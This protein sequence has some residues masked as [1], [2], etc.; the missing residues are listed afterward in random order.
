M[1]D[2][3]TL[4]VVT[5]IDAKLQE[6]CSGPLQIASETAQTSF[7]VL[8]AC[9][10]YTP[11]EC[12]INSQDAE[13]K[14]NFDEQPATRLAPAAAEPPDDLPSEPNHLQ[15]AKE[16]PVK[17][18]S[19]KDEHEKECIEAITEDV[20]RQAQDG[21]SSEP[22]PLAERDPK[23]AAYLAIQE[24]V[25]GA[26]A[27]ETVDCFDCSSPPLE[28]SSVQSVSNQEADKTDEADNSMLFTNIEPVARMRVQD[29][30]RSPARPAKYDHI[31][32]KLYHSTA[33]AKAK[34]VNSLERRPSKCSCVVHCEGGGPEETMLREPL[35]PSLFRMACDS[36]NNTQQ[37]GTRLLRLHAPSGTAIVQRPHTRGMP[38]ETANSGLPSVFARS[39]TPTPTL[40]AAGP[41]KVS[42][43]LQKRSINPIQA[44]ELTSAMKPRIYYR[45]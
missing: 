3:N 32:S 14:Q 7:H 43:L 5:S 40:L 11:G 15:P 31:K 22:G 24:Q 45:K 37:S 13:H 19:A 17:D 12:T 28:S 36:N 34:R 18:E 30:L 41:G 1:Q 20:T 10:L 42:P 38:F 35:K 21:D 39:F 4:R 27:V 6:P 33:A 44:V 26:I 2:A 25:V 16:V 8:P 9:T 23:S 29:P